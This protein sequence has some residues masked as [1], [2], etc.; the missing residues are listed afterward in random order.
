MFV[1]D[2]IFWLEHLIFMPR[3]SVDEKWET[4][5]INFFCGPSRSLQR[6]FFSDI[7]AIPMIPCLPL[8]PF[9]C[10]ETVQEVRDNHLEAAT[11]VSMVA[12]D[13]LFTVS[14]SLGIIFGMS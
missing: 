5:A 11:F 1:R 6:L 4:K 3:V 7:K 10:A 14:I 9:F 13:I 2:R 8:W 12:C